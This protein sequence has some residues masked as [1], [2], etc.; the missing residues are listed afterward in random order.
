MLLNAALKLTFLEEIW[1]ISNFGWLYLNCCNLGCCF[2]IKCFTNRMYY[3]YY[4]N[5]A[6]FQLYKNKN[7]LI[8]GDLAKQK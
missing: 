5:I 3:Y 6:N 8:T 7:E 2:N 4:E 1:W